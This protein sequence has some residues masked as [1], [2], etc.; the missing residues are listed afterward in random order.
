MENEDE[1]SLAWVTDG[2]FPLR[3]LGVEA[4]RQERLAA[5]LT[6]EDVVD[7]ACQLLCAHIAGHISEGSREISSLKNLINR[8]Y[9]FTLLILINRGSFDWLHNFLFFGL[10]SLTG[11]RLVTVFHRIIWVDILTTL[12]V[13]PLL[14]KTL[15]VRR[16]F[17]ADRF[18]S[19]LNLL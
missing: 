3:A 6:I 12:I 5:V 11:P 14:S 9:V 8:S 16:W 1:A 10:F 2:V 7:E 18:Q 13:I 15:S 17:L 19:L 4:V